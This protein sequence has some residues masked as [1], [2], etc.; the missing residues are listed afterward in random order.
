M[1]ET[2]CYAELVYA[3][4]HGPDV[5]PEGG[6]A[7]IG[8]S[9]L[10]VRYRRGRDALSGVTLTIQAGLYGLL[11][12]NGA[13]K[14]T[15]LRVL[16]TL[17]APRSGDAFINGYSVRHQRVAVRRLIGYIPQDVGFYPQLPVWE[18]LDYL[19]RLSGV[20]ERPVRHER[21]HHALAAVDL[22]ERARQPVGTLSVGLR[23][24]LAIAQ[25]LVHD[26][27]IIIADEPTAGL[28]P[29]ERARVRSLLA[30]LAAGRTIVLA[31]HIV[32][33]IAAVCPR[34]A[35][36]NHGRV[37]FEGPTGALAARGRDQLWQATI[38]DEEIAAFM[39]GGW[40]VARLT[41]TPRGTLA[42]VVGARPEGFTR[43]SEAPSVEEGYLAVIGREAPV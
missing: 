18:T 11:G 42:R 10:G 36:L 31:T 28:D 41:R 22:A 33:E 13:G 26:P 8:V 40:P 27:P 9:E 39:N 21:I 30:G 38:P 19:A 3:N 16:A 35:V 4:W 15:L 29:A 14:T 34:A 2:S 37:V 32:A 1:G 20:T 7:M 17:L 12:P 23:Q 5:T 43:V 24:R 25:A 6:G